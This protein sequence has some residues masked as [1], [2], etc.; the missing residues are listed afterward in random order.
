MTLAT[1]VAIHSCAHTQSLYAVPGK[2]QAMQQ[3]QQQQ[4]QV[5]F[6]Q[7][8]HR[9]H[10]Q[11]V[12]HVQPLHQQHQQQV[13]LVQPLHQQQVP[14]V[15][16]LHQ[17]QYQQQ[18]QQM[19]CKPGTP[20]L[21]LGMGALPAAMPAS[22]SMMPIGNMGLAAALQLQQ[23]L[24]PPRWAPATSSAV[25]QDIAQTLLHQV[26]QHHQLPQQQ[27]GVAV[28]LSSPAHEDDLVDE[29]LGLLVK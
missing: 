5:P 16:S 23:P 8:L 4:W 21:T 18:Q 19:Y 2:V 12:P 10:Q 9:Q 27:L 14:L 11:Q 28:P 22:T 26:N 17:H 6:V 29:L 15:Q 20:P 7:S 13:P 24:V 1:P 25:T 3:Q